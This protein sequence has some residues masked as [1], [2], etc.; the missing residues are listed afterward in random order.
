M[1]KEK[2]K[3]ERQQIYILG[4]KMGVEWVQEEESDGQESEVNGL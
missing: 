1:S 4:V 3:E 2:K